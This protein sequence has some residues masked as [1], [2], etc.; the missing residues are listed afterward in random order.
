MSGCRQPIADSVQM[1]P[2]DVA[3]AAGVVA[4]DAVVDAVDPAE[5]LGY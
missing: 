5:L 1:L 3:A 4:M 2:A